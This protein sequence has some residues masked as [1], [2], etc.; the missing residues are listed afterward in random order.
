MVL[1]FNIP[2]KM[3]MLSTIHLYVYLYLILIQFTLFYIT[4]TITISIEFEFILLHLKW[5]E[6]I[7]L[8]IYSI[9]FLFYTSFIM[10]D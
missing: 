2:V 1:P 8:N 10:K 5:I 3:T 4:I 7:A 9:C 6:V